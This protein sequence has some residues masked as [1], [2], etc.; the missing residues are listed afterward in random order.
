[1]QKRILILSGPT[2]EYID[3]VRFIGNASSG[4]MGKAIAEASVGN[5]YAVEF[6]TGPVCRDALPES[7]DMLSIHPVVSAK[8]MLAAASQYFCEADAFVFAAAVADYAPVEKQGRK[9]EGGKDG[10]TLQLVP[11][12]DI[13]KTLCA[14]KKTDQIAIG[15]ALQTHDGEAN[16]R[17]KLIEKNLDGIVL[18]SPASLGATKGSFSY[19][20]P[21][22][23]TFEVWGTI[24]KLNCAGLI[25][26]RISALLTRG[27]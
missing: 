16:A 20:E 23:E 18:N 19:L 26:D 1:M 22:T 27:R 7:S 25:I 8:E 17:R 5:G 2:H 14:K 21:D 9:M 11:N 10:L 24:D 4:R 3:P 15:F 12:P 13:A 6:V